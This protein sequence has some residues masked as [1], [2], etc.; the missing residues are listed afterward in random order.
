MEKAKNA[1]SSFM[2]PHDERHGKDR[3]YDGVGDSGQRTAVGKD[4]NDDGVDDSGQR[5]AVGK[6]TRIPVHRTVD[7]EMRNPV[8]HEVIRPHQHEEVTPV[9]N[10]E[11]HKEEH[12][13]KIQ[14]IK[15]METL[16]D[17]HA[18]K[19]LPVENKAFVHG[20]ERE[21]RGTLDQDTAEYKDTSVT[22]QTEHSRSMA[23]A[24]AGLER[25]HHHVHEH[26]QPVIQKE[27]AAPK[28]VHTAAPVHETHYEKPE[29]LETTVLPAKTQD[30]FERDMQSRERVRGL[31]H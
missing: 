30:E 28:V 1:I 22:S 10:R 23:P 6:D 5:T 27:T 7:K 24:V 3:N 15:S 13:T 14:P 11:I 18:R 9:I 20:N 8:T 25:V 21:A 26:I 16:P 31:G 12:Q 4:R 29:F 17:Q 19:V 2:P